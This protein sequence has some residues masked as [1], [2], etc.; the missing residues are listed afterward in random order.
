MKQYNYSDNFDFL[1]IVIPSYNRYNYLEECVDS[2]HQKVDFPFEIII[3]DDNSN[4]GTK[5]KL[6]SNLSSKVSSIILNNGLSLG[7]AESINRATS[8]AGS[9]Y[10]LMMNS[11]L[12]IEK[13]FFN[14]LVNILK[15]P[16]S[17]YVTPM[18][19]M[20]SGNGFVNNGTQFYVARGIGA[21]CSIGFRKDTWNSVG[22]FN[23]NTCTSGNVDVSFMSRIIKNGYFPCHLHSSDGKV[24]VS[25]M[26]NDRCEG[27]DSTIALQQHDCS[28]PKIFRLTNISYE[29]LSDK[30]KDICNSKMQISYKKY[31]GETNIKYIDDYLKITNEDQTI[32]WE[33]AKRH[34]Q[35][36]WRNEIDIWRLKNP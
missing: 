22:K 12:K 13:G 10:I 35:D 25:N 6:L 28:F 15:V 23:N 14:D 21:G 9:N 34:G 11:D 36:K 7:L 2:I 29:N 19:F 3:H 18:N 31:G 26:S 27:Q 16:F 17:G 4:D 33:K 24:F 20:I 30:H 1:S 32:D 5:E 8:I